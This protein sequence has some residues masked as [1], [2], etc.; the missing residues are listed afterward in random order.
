MQWLEPRA[1]GVVLT[2]S[3]YRALA[4]AACMRLKLA[5]WSIA[6]RVSNAG[7]GTYSVENGVLLVQRHQAFLPPA[8]TQ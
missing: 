3:E 6:G 7:E 5:K 1:N 4:W 2:Y 8:V